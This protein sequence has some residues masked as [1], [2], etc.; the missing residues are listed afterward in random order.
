MFSLVLVHYFH[1][2]NFN[3]PFSW[4]LFTDTFLTVNREWGPSRE[5]RRGS[6]RSPWGDQE[7]RGG[8][9][10]KRGSRSRVLIVANSPATRAAFVYSLTLNI[11]EFIASSWLQPRPLRTPPS[12][13]SFPLLPRTFLFSF[14]IPFSY[15]D[16]Q[17]TCF[18]PFHRT[19]PRRIYAIPLSRLQ[20]LLFAT[21]S[22]PQSSSSSSCRDE[23]VI[24]AA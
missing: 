5:A 22:S 13:L 7:G 10:A 4:C 11:S 8:R 1:A 2:Y 24:G 16:V 20:H 19:Y 12:F 23:E 9:G 6:A 17:T 15:V 18:F 3:S 14:H 21:L